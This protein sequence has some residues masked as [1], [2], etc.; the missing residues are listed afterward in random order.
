MAA[1]L[2]DHPMVLTSPIHWGIPLKLGFTNSLSYPLFMVPTL[3]SFA[4]PLQSWAI[5]YSWGYTFSNGLPWPLTVPSS[6]VLHDTFM[7]SKPVP[8]GW[9][10]HITK[11]SLQLGSLCKTASLCS[12]KTLP[13]NFHLS[14]AGFFIITVYFLA[15]ANQHQLSQSFFPFLTLEPESHG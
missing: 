5:N 4:W 14:D 3:K 15:P 8:P 7:P 13:R 9:L 12:Q 10:L 6:A 11:S 1:F 2:G